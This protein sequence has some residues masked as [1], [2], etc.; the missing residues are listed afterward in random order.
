M[1]REPNFTNYKRQKNS[2]YL[3]SDYSAS[4]Y[5]SDI[6]LNQNNQAFKNFAVNSYNNNNINNNINMQNNFTNKQQTLNSKANFLSKNFTENKNAYFNTS[7]KQRSTSKDSIPSRNFARDLSSNLS[8]LTLSRGGLSGKVLDTRPTKDPQFIKECMER[9]SNIYFT[10]N[11]GNPMNMSLK[12]LTPPD[13]KNFLFLFKFFLRRMLPNF[14]YDPPKVDEGILNV[15][16]ILKYPGIVHKNSILAMGAPGAWSQLILLLHWMAECANFSE[17]VR[18]EFGVLNFELEEKTIKLSSEKFDEFHK[19]M[20]LLNDDIVL[21]DSYHSSDFEGIES[22]EDNQ[23]ALEKFNKNRDCRL[24]S[25]GIKKPIK[26]TIEE[27]KSLRQE[28]KQEY[29][30]NKEIAKNYYQNLEWRFLCEGFTEFNKTK[31]VE[32]AF[33]VIKKKMEY[34]ESFFNRQLERVALTNSKTTKKGS[35]RDNMRDELEKEQK[36]L[37]DLSTQLALSKEKT[38]TK[39]KEINEV[40]RKTKFLELESVTLGKEIEELYIERER[41]KQIVE[42]QDMTVEEYKRLIESNEALLEEINILD[43]KLQE[44]SSK[45]EEANELIRQKLRFS[46]ELEKKIFEATE[47]ANLDKSKIVNIATKYLKQFEQLYQ[48]IDTNIENKFDEGLKSET[49][50]LNSCNNNSNNQNFYYSTL[51]EQ[52]RFEGICKNL[53]SEINQTSEYL[54]EIKQQMLQQ[55]ALLNEEIQKLQEQNMNLKDC[56]AVNDRKKASIEKDLEEIEVKIKTKKE[57]AE[58]EMKILEEEYQKSKERLQE[59]VQE[60]KRRDRHI[61]EIYAHNKMLTDEYH[62]RN[63]FLLKKL[64]EAQDIYKECHDRNVKKKADNLKQLKIAAKK[65]GKLNDLLISEIKQ[66][67]NDDPLFDENSFFN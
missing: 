25:K 48:Q 50:R 12:E 67:H 55:S 24:L 34:V 5:E 35:A 13:S 64:E 49:S 19:K 2:E 62:K 51:F 3:G 27:L 9:I 44:G 38:E 6:G 53:N 41:Y 56:L 54:Q 46:K 26:P 40:K 61:E 63:A 17:M 29:M 11:S 45:L 58:I 60:N 31:S 65:M 59:L 16:N 23:I 4:D 22:D 18:Q 14:G 43:V 66:A 52:E 39:E 28:V 47:K 7:I 37:E 15:I 1:K 21:D 36:T 42:N 10:M 32:K 20:D 8:A 33:N 30:Q 57:K